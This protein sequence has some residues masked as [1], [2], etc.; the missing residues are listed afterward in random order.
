MGRQFLQPQFVGAILRWLDKKGVKEM[1]ARQMN[2]VIQAANGIIDAIDRPHQEAKPGSGIVAWLNSDDTGQ[3]SL[4][5]ARALAPAA[6]LNATVYGIKSSDP[7]PHDPADIGRC[8][9]LLDTVPEL[10][11]H[12]HRLAT[13]GTHGPVWN[14]I[15]KEC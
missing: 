2:A 9:R 7:W 13:D 11:P 6:G 12:L 4:Y 8:V 1:N 15:A 10:R 3:S 5:M 14:A